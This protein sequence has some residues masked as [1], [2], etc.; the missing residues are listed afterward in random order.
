MKAS[1]V[2]SLDTASPVAKPTWLAEGLLLLNQEKHNKGTVMSK[3]MGSRILISRL[4]LLN[5][6]LLW[7]L[8]N[9]ATSDIGIKAAVDT[10]HTTNIGNLTADEGTN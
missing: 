10:N 4:L 8:G 1:S 7:Q 3:P 9:G 5:F 6:L 2:K